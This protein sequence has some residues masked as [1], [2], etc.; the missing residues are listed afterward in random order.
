MDLPRDPVLLLSLV[1]TY[2]RDNYPNLD[3]LCEDKNWD[4]AEI[5]EKLK[6]IDYLYDE[7]TNQ[8]K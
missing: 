4:K 7:T 3:S 5:S 2:L 8:F 1:N 6:N